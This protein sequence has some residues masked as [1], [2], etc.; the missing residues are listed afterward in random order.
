MISLSQA[1]AWVRQGESETLELKK[2]TGERREAMETV[3][4]MLNHCGGRVI[5]GVEPGGRIVGQMV[6]EKTMEE[7]AQVIQAIEPTVFPVVE[8]V[9][10]TNQL[11]LLIVNI[12]KGHSPPYSLSGPS[13][14]ARRRDHAGAFA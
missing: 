8:K 5:F 12:S 1:E 14:Q 7:V 13:V 3:C 2:S 6:S 9:D 4:G 10:V 11:Q